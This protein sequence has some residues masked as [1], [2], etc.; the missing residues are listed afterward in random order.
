LARFRLKPFDSRVVEPDV[1]YVSGAHADRLHERYVAG[2]PDLIVEV[3][4]P[5]SHRVDKI[6]KR[7]LYEAHGV[8]EYWI[9]DP[10]AETLEVY[11]RPARTLRFSGASG[12]RH[13]RDAAA[14]W[15]ADPPA[16]GLRVS[17]ARPTAPGRGSLRSVS[18]SLPQVLAEPQPRGTTSGLRLY[19]Q[20]G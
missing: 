7:R 10:V 3:L 14:A 8:R 17:D 6:K 18:R 16:R 12:R 19:Q 9:V 5:P 11:R 15:T 2:A 20:R 1:L 13:P 4:S